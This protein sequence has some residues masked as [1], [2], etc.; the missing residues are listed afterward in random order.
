MLRGRQV[1]GRMVD[2]VPCPAGAFVGMLG[3]AAGS[4][5]VGGGTIVGS[6]PATT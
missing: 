6:G 3:P 4:V 2:V 5:L 1:G